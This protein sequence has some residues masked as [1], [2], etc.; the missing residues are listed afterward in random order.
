[1]WRDASAWRSPRPVRQGPPGADGAPADPAE[2][3]AL[4][5]AGIARVRAEVRDG[6]DGRDADPAAVATMVVAAVAASMRAASA[7]SAPA[8]PRPWR[9]IPHRDEVT[10]MILYIDLIPL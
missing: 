1:M 7:D 4:V 6:A 2:I 10:D 5:D 3:R 8:A 9:L